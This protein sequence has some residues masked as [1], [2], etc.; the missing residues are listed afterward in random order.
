MPLLYRYEAELMGVFIYSTSALN[1]FVAAVLESA[2]TLMYAYGS[3]LLTPRISLQKRMT[4]A[5]YYS[6]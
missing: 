6:L 3:A 4:H 2:R 5:S 1:Y